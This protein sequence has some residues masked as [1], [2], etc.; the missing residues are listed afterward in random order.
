LQLTFNMVLITAAYPV[1]A[2]MNG[3]Y[4]RPDTIE[5]TIPYTGASRAFSCPASIA[6]GRSLPYHVLLDVRT[7]QAS[8][9]LRSRWI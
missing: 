6:H 3:D 4:L 2:N 8:S 5:S 7:H 9:N 1:C